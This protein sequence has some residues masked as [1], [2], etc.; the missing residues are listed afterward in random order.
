MIK[1][2]LRE[3]LKMNQSKL[4]TLSSLLDDLRTKIVSNELQQERVTIQFNNGVRSPLSYAVR[5]SEL[6]EVGEQLH[7]EEAKVASEHARLEQWHNRYDGL[8]KLLGN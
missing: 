4:Q 8:L 5:L 3:Q 6:A 7:D 2:W 1:K